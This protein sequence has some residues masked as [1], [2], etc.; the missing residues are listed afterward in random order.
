MGCY[1]RSATG[2]LKY[3]GRKTG[4]SG[5]E[6][7]IGSG[8][9][10]E[11]VMSS[12]SKRDAAGEHLVGSWFGDGLIRTGRSGIVG[13]DPLN[14]AFFAIATDGGRRRQGGV[15]RTLKIILY[16]AVV[17]QCPGEKQ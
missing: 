14:L 16:P 9:Q 12:G 13:W 6:P 7:A 3:S 1:G 11:V 5:R 10:G 4:G 15:D 17:E 8:Q 2:R